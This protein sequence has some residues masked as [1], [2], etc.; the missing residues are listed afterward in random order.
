MFVLIFAFN[1]VAIHAFVSSIYDSTLIADE[2][3]WRFI[4]IMI[5]W[6]TVLLLSATII[7]YR[8]LITHIRVRE[9]NREFLE[10]LML[11]FTH[12]LG[13]F[14]S[15]QIINLII[16][17]DRY[18]DKAVDRLLEEY[19]IIMEDMD[20][21]IKIIEGFKS[22]TMKE[23]ERL[24]IRS[25]IKEATDSINEYKENKRIIVNITDR[26]CTVFAIQEELSIIIYLLLDNAIRYSDKLIHIR[27]SR[28]NN[29]IILAV[30]NDIKEESSKGT[31]MGLN[32]VKKLCRRYRIKLKIKESKERFTIVLAV[33]T[34]I[35]Q[36]L[37]SYL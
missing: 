24:D 23:E 25:M 5:V 8:L 2:K 22:G 4:T 11:S 14:L 7:F 36:R 12:K 34:G 13:N 21:L 6:E 9:K 33:K 17:Q 31:G 37:I 32:I 15:S 30:R 3:I 10:I 28:L 1:I 20:Q 26:K 29:Q 16:L 35:Y 27:L 19:S 18:K